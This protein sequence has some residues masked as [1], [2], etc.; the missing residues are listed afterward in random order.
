M[1]EHT[2][3]HTYI[4]ISKRTLTSRLVSFFAFIAASLGVS[5]LNILLNMMTI[6]YIYMIVVVV[7]VRKELFWLR[8]C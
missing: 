1:R 8:D 3:T 6:V 4:Y 7:F 5:F 2:H